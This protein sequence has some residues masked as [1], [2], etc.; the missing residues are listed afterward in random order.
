M[1]GQCEA[2][3]E[4]FDANTRLCSLCSDACNSV[5]WHVAVCSTDCAGQ[6]SPFPARYSLLRLFSTLIVSAISDVDK[7]WTC[8]DKDKDKDQ[9]YKDQTRTRTRSTCKD[10]DKDLT[11]KDEDKD[12]D[13][14]LVLK[15]SLMTRT[16]TSLTVTY[17]N[18]QLNLQSLSSSN[19]E[20]TVKVRNMTVKPIILNK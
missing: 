2:V 20:H 9:A 6:H 16:R 11:H 19:N 15:K 1:A 13:L 7:D 12:N 5:V 17:W 4:Y 18:L 10:K 14:N 8:K 3:V